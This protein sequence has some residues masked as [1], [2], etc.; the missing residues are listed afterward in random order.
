LRRRSVAARLPAA[1]LRRPALSARLPAIG[2]R[3]AF[4]LAR[5]PAF[6]LRR[7]V[8]ARF[9]LA[10]LRPGTRGARPRV[11]FA[12][13]A[14]QRSLRLLLRVPQLATREKPDLGVRMT[15]LNLLE[16]RQQLVA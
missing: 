12:A 7:T 2:S 16:G 11:P 10:G 3:W 9:P 15:H 5:L 1:S 4:F 8:V 13:L 14:D 6:A